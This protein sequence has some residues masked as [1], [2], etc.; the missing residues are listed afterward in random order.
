MIA[1]SYAAMGSGY[2][3]LSS[4]SSEM[5]DFEVIRTFAVPSLTFGL[6]IHFM[7]LGCDVHYADPTSNFSFLFDTLIC[8]DFC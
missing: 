5:R 4:F 6:G 1:T 2:Y 8:F 3:F 7:C